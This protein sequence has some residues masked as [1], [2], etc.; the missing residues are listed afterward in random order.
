M[1]EIRGIFEVHITVGTDGDSLHRLWRYCSVR[2]TIKPV[3]AVAD[4]GVVK[5]QYMISKYKAGS[6]SQ[7]ISSAK[8]MASQLKSAGLAVIRV[9]VEAMANNDGVPR[10]SADY[11]E[12]A[13]NNAA[14]NPKPYFEFHT[15]IILGKDHVYEDLQKTLAN[16]Q[17]EYKTDQVYANVS[18]NLCGSKVP[19]MTLRI[20]EMGRDAAYEIKDKLFHLVKSQ[21]FK[22]DGKT[23]YEFSIYDSNETVDHGWLL[24][25]KL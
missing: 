6:A 13:A 9:K 22:M 3:L 1:G 12:Y 24:P 23:Q 21:G 20:Y 4:S 17:N 19:L 5:N 10:S 25:A 2:P 11:K 18:V 14:V 7:M 15:K 8:L 16:F